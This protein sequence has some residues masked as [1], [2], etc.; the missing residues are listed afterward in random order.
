VKPMRE[1]EVIFVNNPADDYALIM[2]FWFGDEQI[3]VVRRQEKSLVVDLYGTGRNPVV[4]PLDWLIEKLKAIQR[5]ASRSFKGTE[6]CY[7]GQTVATIEGQL[8]DMAVY[9]YGTGRK[10]VVVLL[11]WLLQQLQTGREDLLKDVDH[12]EI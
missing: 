1:W 7:E 2:E 12:T 5:D 10:S 4:I 8:G 11:D 3:A 6:I 9:L